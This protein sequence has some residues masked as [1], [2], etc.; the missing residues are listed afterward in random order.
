TT[1]SY[2][3]RLRITIFDD[4]DEVVGNEISI[5][6]DDLGYQLTNNGNAAALLNGNFIVTW[7]SDNDNNQREVFGQIFNPEGETVTELFTVNDDD[8]KNYDYSKVISTSNGGFICTYSCYDDMAI[9]KRRFDAEGEPQESGAQVA[10][11]DYT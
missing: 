5:D 9:Y 8:G 1:Y 4:K 2:N 10:E 7:A 11:A 6:Q 3:Y